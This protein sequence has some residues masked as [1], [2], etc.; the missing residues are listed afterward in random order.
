M[1]QAIQ[2]AEHHAAKLV[3][4][5]KHS[6]EL[7]MAW[8]VRGGDI[9]PDCDFVLPRCNG[10]NFAL[11]ERPASRDDVWTH[12]QAVRIL[13]HKE[14]V[15]TLLRGIDWFAYST[16]SSGTRNL[17]ISSIYK[18]LDDKIAENPV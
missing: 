8:E 15:A 12:I 13:C 3:V 5:G 4:S 16:P 14:A 11:T 6:H 1:K 7:I 10:S 17:R 2:S 9:V 18:A